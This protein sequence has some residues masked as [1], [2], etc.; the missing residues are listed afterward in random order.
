M[1]STNMVSGIM[2][3]MV[4]FV[5]MAYA[6]SNSGMTFYDDAPAKEGT[7]SASVPAF[8]FNNGETKPPREINWEQ[9]ARLGSHGNVTC[10][11]DEN[12]RPTAVFVIGIA[13]VST[14]MIAVEA[15]E[16]ARFEAEINAKEA[17]ALWMHECI[18]VS[19]SRSNSTLVVRTNGQ[20]SSETVTQST[21]VSTQMVNASWRGMSIFADLLKDGRY[22]AVWRWCVEEQELARMVEML[23]QDASP[24]QLGRK[25]NMRVDEHG[26]MFRED[27]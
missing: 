14:T 21:R 26:L 16:E 12:K 3:S 1:K 17:F 4:C 9:R 13:P 2:A 15:E 22:I 20:E 7:K 25:A 24:D 6:E 11:T 23:A 27:Y 10:Y 18:G 8:T 5:M 19:N